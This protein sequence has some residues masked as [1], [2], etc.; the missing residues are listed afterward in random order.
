VIG[1]FMHHA[2]DGTLTDV[3]EGVQALYDLVIT[4]MDW[5]SGFWDWEEALPVG[6]IG[7]LGGFE[8]IGEVER[9]IAQR[10]HEE[11]AAAWRHENVPPV[12][13]TIRSL[14]SGLGPGGMADL[15]GKQEPAPHDHVWSS[16]GRCMW[17]VCRAT[18]EDQ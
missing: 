12:P 11:E 18:R 8:K 14:V 15:L 7:R 10:R 16:V 4:S 17:P 13:F 5:G 2:E 9:Y 3:T 1:R 6:L